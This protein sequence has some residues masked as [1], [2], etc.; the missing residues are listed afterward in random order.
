MNKNLT[1]MILIAVLFVGAVYVYFIYNKNNSQSQPEETLIDENTVGEN[2]SENDKAKTENSNLPTNTSTTNPNKKVALT[3]CSDL[4]SKVVNV[5][6]FKTFNNKLY[7]IKYPSFL[8]IENN[9]LDSTFR[10]ARCSSGYLMNIFYKADVFD[11]SDAVCFATLNDFQKSQGGV[12]NIL[13]IQIGGREATRG[14]SGFGEQ[15]QID[16]IRVGNS[17]FIITHT[18]AKNEF[19]NNLFNKMLSTLVFY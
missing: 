19:I 14:Y 8:T 15:T 11:C 12:S 7:S 5:S 16:T 9:A 18:M 13:R 10:D 3:S 17:A 2:N 4:F 6:E 1:L